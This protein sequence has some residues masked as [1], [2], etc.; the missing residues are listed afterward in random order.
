MAFIYFNTC[1]QDYD[2][3]TISQEWD[4]LVNDG[5]CTVNTDVTY[6]YTLTVKG[7]GT[8]INKSLTTPSAGIA[9]FTAQFPN[10]TDGN[11]S[12]LVFAGMYASLNSFNQIAISYAPEGTPVFTTIPISSPTAFHCFEFKWDNVAGTLI[13]RQDGNVIG[14]ASGL[15]I[16]TTG[17]NNFGFWINNNNGITCAVMAIADL[18]GPAPWNDLVGEVKPF[19]LLPTNAGL[20]TEWSNSFSANNYAQVNS[21][22]APGDASYLTS[23]TVNQIDLYE[24][25]S[26]PADAISVACVMGK[27]NA[28]K[29]VGGTRYVG[30]ALYNGSTVNVSTGQGIASGSYTEYETAMAVNPYT[31]ANWALADF[32][33]LQIGMKVTA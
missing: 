15:S 1:G 4:T 31:S 10:N 2:M 12:N 18:T 24:V 17:N 3:T 9:N 25:G 26:I 6:G 32:T 33:G 30:Y 19:I 11:T 13:I 20:D 16:P 29:L 23:D 22:I 28:K 14:T 5:A 8:L 21:R 27:I 7:G